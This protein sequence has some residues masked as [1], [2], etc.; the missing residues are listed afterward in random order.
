M[1]K[2][3]GLSPTMREKSVGND[4]ALVESGLGKLQD[5][6]LSQKL[7]GKNETLKA[8]KTRE[9]RAL[10]IEKAMELFARKGFTRTRISDITDGLNIGKGTFY[11]YFKDKL[12]LFSECMDV[13]ATRVQ[14]KDVWP[15]IADEG[16]TEKIL[17]QRAEAFQK[18]F[19]QLSGILIILRRS[20]RMDDPKYVIMTREYLRRLVGPMV[21]DLQK[22]IEAA[23][24]RDINVN[25]A[26]Y[27]LLSLFETVGYSLMVDPSLT[28]EKLIK[29]YLDIVKYGIMK[30]EVETLKKEAPDEVRGEI[31]DSGGTKT[32]I[33]NIRFGGEH[34]L[35]ARLGKS[36]VHIDPKRVA[37]I[38]FE[39]N[40]PVCNAV[41]NMKNEE[42]LT[43]QTEGNMILSGDV[44]AGTLTIP[45]MDISEIVFKS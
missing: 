13:V 3:S 42:Q 24:L 39:G 23:S 1:K 30:P 27:L 43:V 2:E 37:S 41:V 40:G 34:Y 32:W 8:R 36:E 31:K 7:T 35:A 26:A 20:L 4:Q 5:A 38:S 21:K 19:P 14:P 25:A 28:F 6:L 18:A 16:G 15:F 45:I 44:S 17:Y 9:K 12:E 33:G 11:L 22:G 29:P 10:I